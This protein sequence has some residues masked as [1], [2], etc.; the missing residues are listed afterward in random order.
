[1]SIIQ[2]N[3]SWES[4]QENI[5]FDMFVKFLRQSEIWIT[6]SMPRG[7]YALLPYWYKIL[8]NLQKTVTNK[9]EQ[10]GYDQIKLPQ[11]IPE[12][13][14][15]HLNKTWLFHTKN[16]DHDFF[17]VSW[18]ETLS[19]V[20]FIEKAAI[21]KKLPVKYYNIAD[22]FR[23][24]PKTRFLK[25]MEFNMCEINSFWSTKG[26]AEKEENTLNTTFMHILDDLKIKYIQTSDNLFYNT[27]KKLYCYF[28]FFKKFWSIFCTKLADNEYM[29]NI[30]WHENDEIYQV[31]ASFTDR[32][33]S[34]YLWA[35][36]DKKWFIIAKEISPYQVYIN[37]D[38]LSQEMFDILL[39]NFSNLDIKYLTDEIKNPQHNYEYF[40]A[41]GIPISISSWKHQLHVR[42]R[43][44]NCGHRLETDNIQQQL[45][46]L[47]SEYKIEY[48]DNFT[49]AP[50]WEHLSI[51]DIMPNTV[52]IWNHE[53]GLIA[54][55]LWL[56]KL[57]YIS[58]DIAYVKWVI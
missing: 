38:K 5:N 14:V 34:L 39:Q 36:M 48:K 6:N 58:K 52:Y 33:L 26:E 10:L 47:L 35:H 25:N 45:Y 28:P 1:M 11:I 20:A 53:S 37:K 18:Y 7:T 50:L 8:E 49:T 21:N 24:V 44:E 43:I 56:K 41:K 32:I 54:Q 9:I 23:Q 31:N 2:P 55:N 57:W 16:E 12:E 4:E 17:L 15:K 19:A 40:N 30:K 51:D 3:K 46:T 13:Y 22:V 42:S 27:Q 29:K